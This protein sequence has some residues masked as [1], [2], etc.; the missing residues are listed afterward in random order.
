MQHYRVY[1]I[2]AADQVTGRYEIPYPSDEAAIA[3]ASREFRG[4]SIEIW[5]GVR[6]VMT[7]ASNHDSQS[8]AALHRPVNVIA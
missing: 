4:K 1:V 6:C 5:Q 7:Y 3:G 8:E 2:D